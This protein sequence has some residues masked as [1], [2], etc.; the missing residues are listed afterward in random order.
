[1]S[2]NL[3]LKFKHHNDNEVERDCYIGQE[4]DTNFDYD[5]VDDRIV[6]MLRQKSRQREH[7]ERAINYVSFEVSTTAT[8]DDSLSLFIAENDARLVSF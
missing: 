6:L 4:L 2:S 1:M 5:D 7:F 8:A 3:P